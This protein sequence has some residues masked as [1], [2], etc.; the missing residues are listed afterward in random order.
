MATYIAKRIIIGKMQYDVIVPLYPEYKVDI[1]E[2]L[3]AEG[4]QDLIV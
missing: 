3:T 4:K 2:I 1:D